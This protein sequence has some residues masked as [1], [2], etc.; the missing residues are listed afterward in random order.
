MLGW[1]RDRPGAMMAAPHVRHPAVIARPACA[2][3][4]IRAVLAA[5]ADAGVLHRYEDELDVALRAGQGA[6]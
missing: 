6:R 4:A 2:P 1:R 3:S 5:N